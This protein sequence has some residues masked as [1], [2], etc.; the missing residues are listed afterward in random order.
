MLV[1][2]GADM[3]IKNVYGDT[4]LSTAVRHRSYSTVKALLS[5]GASTNTTNLKGHFPLEI[6]MADCYVFNIYCKSWTQENIVSGFQLKIK[7]STNCSV[8]SDECS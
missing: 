7:G 3:S 8:M 5:D 2:T 1:K 4:P 6:A